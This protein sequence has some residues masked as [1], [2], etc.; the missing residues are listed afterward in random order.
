M[1]H[2]FV[3]AAIEYCGFLARTGWLRGYSLAME[4]S[5]FTVVYNLLSMAD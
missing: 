1:D 4:T 2:C 3:E 5:D